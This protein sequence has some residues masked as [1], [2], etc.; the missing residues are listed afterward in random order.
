M[1][2]IFFA[3]LGALLMVGTVSAQKTFDGVIEYDMKY[4]GEG[5]DMFA[6]MMP[7]SYTYKFEGTNMKFKMNGGMM[8]AMM[9]TMVVKT[10][11]KEPILYVIKDAEQKAYKI[12]V[13]EEN[14]EDE[15][16]PDVTITKLDEVITIGGYECQKWEVVTVTDEGDAT[17]HIWATE[18]LVIKRPKGS[19]KMK[20]GGNLFVDGV[21][22][23]P[24]KIMTTVNMGG[25]MVTMIQTASEIKRG[26]FPRNEFDVPEGYEVEE[27]TMEELFGGMMG[28]GN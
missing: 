25:M 14:E 11:K 19:D 28:G 12:A 10:E 22:G 13:E 15:E 17:Q 26:E 4:M 21:K 8:A 1:K 9:G 5:A 24:L 6:S 20:G 16:K 27:T 2:K 3:L 7:S 18:D 23:F